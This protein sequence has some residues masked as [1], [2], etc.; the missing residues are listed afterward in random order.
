MFMI[1][2]EQT[3]VMNLGWYPEVPEYLSPAAAK[4]VLGRLLTRALGFQIATTYP[5]DRPWSVELRLVAEGLVD[6]PEPRR[7]LECMIREGM[8]KLPLFPLPVESET[9]EY[10]LVGRVAQ[11]LALTEVD[12]GFA[13]RS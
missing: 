10:P 1:A 7:V 9:F 2:S 11:S 12:P 4:Q 3:R 5:A 6:A 8:P 13:H